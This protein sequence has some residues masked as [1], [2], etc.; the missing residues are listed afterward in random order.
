MLPGSLPSLG[1]ASVLLEYALLMLG[2][3]C[4]LV[5]VVS[6]TWSKRSDLSKDN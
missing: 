1:V 2:R 3:Q 6:S 4:A 5:C